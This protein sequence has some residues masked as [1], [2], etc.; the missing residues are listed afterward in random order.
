MTT[1][2]FIPLRVRTFHS[3]PIR[4]SSQHAIDRL[5]IL[6]T[7]TKHKLSTKYLDLVD[8]T[9]EKWLFQRGFILNALPHNYIDHR[10]S[11]L[12]NVSHNLDLIHKILDR[13]DSGKRRG[14]VGLF[15]LCVKF[16]KLFFLKKNQKQL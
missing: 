9:T 6:T 16:A 3:E 14:G 4:V 15:L 11:N 13:H 7:T 2:L 8:Q 5:K 1:H 10:P 12:D